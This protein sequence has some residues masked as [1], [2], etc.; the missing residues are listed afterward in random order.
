M[1]QWI[2]DLSARAVSHWKWI[3]TFASLAIIGGVVKWLM[4]IRKSWHEGSD[5]RESRAERRRERA[6]QRCYQRIAAIHRSERTGKGFTLPRKPSKPL[7]ER[8]EIWE[9]AWFRYRKEVEE[10]FKKN[11][12]TSYMPDPPV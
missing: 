8:T 11:Y 1:W 10:E 4:E 12:G 9:E 5:A 7:R 3:G 2:R 6:V